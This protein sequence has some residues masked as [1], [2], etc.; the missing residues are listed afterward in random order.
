MKV[1]LKNVAVVLHE[2]HFPENIGSVARVV[3]NMGLGQLIVVNP[4]DCDLTRI[5]RLA[6]HAAE[7]VVA[8]MEVHDTLRDALAPFQFIVGTTQ[9]WD[10]IAT[11]S[12]PHGAWP[13]NW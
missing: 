2:P 10:R 4:F 9:G 3:K 1:N 8:E 13:R 6:T 12:R 11:A 5:L 7:D